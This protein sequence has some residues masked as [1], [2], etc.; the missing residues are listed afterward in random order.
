MSNLC[1][2]VSAVFRRIEPVIVLQ[3]LASALFDTALQMVVKDRCANAT[4]P[5]TGISTEDSRQKAMSDFYMT[6]NLIA[7]LTPILPALLLARLGDRGWRKAPIVSPQ[8]G[9]LLSRLTLLLV[10]VLRGPLR[11][12]WAGAA[13]H[14]LAGGFCSYWAGVMALVSLGS[15][16]KDR[17]K[18]MMRVE[19]LYGTAGLVGSLVSGHLFRLYSSIGQGTVLVSVSTLLYLVC[20]VYSVLLLQV[21]QV[22]DQEESCGLMGNGTGDVPAAPPPGRSNKVNLALLFAGGVLYDVAV[23]GA[24]E[25]LVTFQMK[26]PLNWNATQVGYGNAA[27]FVI[28]LT[29]F[30]GVMVM[31]RCV[32]DVTLILIGMLSFASGIYFMAF[33]TATYMF[34]LARSLM[35]FALIPM[36]TIRSL[37][38]Q[39]VQGSSYGITLISLQVAF[40]VASLAYT[41]AYTKIYQSSLDWFPGF[42]FTLSSVITVLG[43]IP[44]SIVGC[45]LPQRQRYERIQGD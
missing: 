32:S 24:M 15:T 7:K 31:S 21:K 37:L 42:I 4:D 38:S 5:G 1:D 16:A 29:S 18:V 12:M 27:G 22:P 36:P 43:T 13:L 20:L 41:P 26:E 33:V 19:L 34:Y 17:S 40:K 3:Q 45:R 11:A 39:Q 25:I 10:I 44:I 6:Y 23:G 9:Y 28:F 14:G 2:T 35:L 30:L 8:I